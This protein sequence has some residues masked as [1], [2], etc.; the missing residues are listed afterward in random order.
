MKKVHILPSV[1]LM[2]LM[3]FSCGSETSSE[4][5]KD[6]KHDE[7][8]KAFNKK[9]EEYNQNVEDLCDCLKE[10]GDENYCLRF[11]NGL[12]FQPTQEM[13][14][15]LSDEEYNLDHVEKGR[16]RI[17]DCKAEAGI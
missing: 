7:A 11:Y 3:L 5:S 17:E 12:S 6:E 1:F 4:N 15:H 8:F 13:A 10:S 14:D 9:V 2:A 16:Q